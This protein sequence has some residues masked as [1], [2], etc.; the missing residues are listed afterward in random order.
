MFSNSN[1][2]IILLV[3]FTILIFLIPFIFYLITLQNTLKTI[4]PE[5]RKMA[6]ANVW[7]LFIPFFNWIYQFIVVNNIADSIRAEALVKSVP[8]E[9]SRPGASVG[10]AMCV[11]QIC[12]IIPVFGTLASLGFIVCWIVYWVKINSYKKLLEQAVTF[13][14]ERQ[15]LL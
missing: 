3:C 9:E 2:F 8:L 10:I 6:P 15:D 14:F 11:L 7:L 4:S 12:S 13:D 1:E 5:N